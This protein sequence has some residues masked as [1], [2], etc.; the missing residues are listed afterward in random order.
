MIGSCRPFGAAPLT[1]EDGTDRL[2][3]TYVT[4]TNQRC[5]T[6]QKN[7]DLMYISVEAC[8]RTIYLL[9]YVSCNDAIPRVQTIVPYSGMYRRNICMYVYIVRINIGLFSETQKSIFSASFSHFVG[10]G[11]LRVFR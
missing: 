9:I 10:T 6:S 1:L 5:V 3:Q 7:E 11:G 2:S 8:H 4:R